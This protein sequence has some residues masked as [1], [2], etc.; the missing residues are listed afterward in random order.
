MD[1]LASAARPIMRPVSIMTAQCSPMDGLHFHSRLKN[2]VS[3]GLTICERRNTSRI[4]KLIESQ[5]ADCA[6][7]ARLERNNSH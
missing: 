2:S 7:N 6:E 4:V 1:T 3:G 5:V